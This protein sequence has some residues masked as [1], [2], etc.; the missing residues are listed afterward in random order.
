MWLLFYV[1]PSAEVNAL[2]PPTTAQYSDP[3]SNTSD[4]LTGATSLTTVGV[5]PDTAA[6]VSYIRSAV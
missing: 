5:L 6:N 2:P 1:P 4:K 3:P